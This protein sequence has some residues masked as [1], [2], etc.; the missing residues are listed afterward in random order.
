MEFEKTFSIKECS[1][2]YVKLTNGLCF[3]IES[4]IIRYG[5][6]SDEFKEDIIY[7]S[8]HGYRE[9]IPQ[10]ELPLTDRCNMSCVYC[11]FRGRSGKNGKPVDMDIEVA[12]KAINFFKEYI[13]SINAPYARIDFGVTGEP[14]LRKD[15]HESV[16]SIVEEVFQESNVNALWAGPYITNAIL[17]SEPDIADN[18]GVPQDVSCDG[19]KEV[20]DAMRK[21]PNGKG[22][23]DDVRKSID[24]ILEKHPLIGVSAVLT[25]KYT[26]FDKVFLH[27]YEEL[28]F[29]CIYMKPVNVTHDIDYS[30]NMQN[31]DLFK[32]G[33]T[34]LVNLILKQSKVKMFC[35]LAALNCEDFFMRL[36]YR[37]KDLS[38]QIY[39]CGAGKSG[40]YVDTDGKLYP[41]SH[42]IG[43]TEFSIG[44][45]YRGVNQRYKEKF[46]SLHVDNREPCKKCWARYLCGGGCYYQSMLANGNIDVPDKAKCELIKHLCLEAIRLVTFLSVEAPDVLAAFPEPYYIS[47]RQLRK[48]HS[49]RYIPESFLKKSFKN[50]FIEFTRHGR[51]KGNY[52]EET[53]KIY[54]QISHN[55]NKIKLTINK[56]TEKKFDVK[57]LFFDTEKEPIL[58]SD[59]YNLK[60]G[61][62]GIMFKLDNEGRLYKLDYDKKKIR[63][64][65]YQN[66]K[67]IPETKA[68][69]EK[70]ADDVIVTFSLKEIFKEGII[71]S[72]Y[73]FNIIIEFE[74]GG[75]SS[76]VQYEP[77]CM[78]STD[79]EGILEPAG[80]EFDFYNQ[81]NNEINSLKI[82]GMYPIG[83]WM[84]MKP[85]VC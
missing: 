17:A 9:C 33:Y 1:D 66:E 55:D 73:G 54:M 2:K 44:D 22:T 58:M 81:N 63:R 29:R 35:Y 12:Y 80:G 76:L 72:L 24:I 19:P 20:H 11:S 14:F 41:C 5:D 51:I 40:V 38:K 23:Y 4:G 74:E 67:W 16:F 79:I 56:K 64:I 31:V 32:E 75:W 26:E 46:L 42:F 60:H 6:P 34:K 52:F 37:V 57:I 3:E 68:F 27:L 36:V 61:L 50:K 65:P 85:N 83:R 8:S 25:A 49:D 21:Y 82:R 30:L 62:K 77:F 69:V 48:S 10:L 7:V 45:I 39:R 71:P 15:I 78:V 13:E 18:L 47:E 43:R 59:L 28:G 53:P 84:G 70:H